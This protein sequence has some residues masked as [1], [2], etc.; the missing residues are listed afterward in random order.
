MLYHRNLSAHL[1]VIVLVLCIGVLAP[2][3]SSQYK[4]ATAE[5]RSTIDDASKAVGVY[6]LQMN[7]FER[8]VY[9]E[10]VLVDPSLKVLF[11]DA[12]G[13]RTGLTGD[14][15]SRESIQARMDA[16]KLVGKYAELLASLAD[17]DAPAKFKSGA[18]AL[19]T[20]LSSLSDRFQ[21][22]ANPTQEDATASKFVGPLSKLIG[23]V[24]EMILAGRRD[25]AIEEGV[26]NGAPAVRTIL[27]LLKADCELAIE[28]L[29][30]VGIKQMLA[31]KINFYNQNRGTL[32][33]DQRAARL[34]EI[35]ALAER[36]DTLIEADPSSLIDAMNEAH[37]ALVA[38]VTDSGNDDKRIAL[39]QKA[40]ALK[41]EASSE[42]STVKSIKGL[43]EVIIN[44]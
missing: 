12:Q 9:L 35:K 14:T 24:G 31:E 39:I 4:A 18:D 36:Y 44:D 17:S 15:F 8:E 6:F 29:Q 10:S 20:N 26:K 5:F 37:E 7:S 11:V 32:S 30:A 42:L 28:P 27:S 1:E 43:K 38:Y 34:K 3:C 21:K 19:G 23:A 25:A 41:T 40:A 13:K 2:G 22:L 33:Y 16:I